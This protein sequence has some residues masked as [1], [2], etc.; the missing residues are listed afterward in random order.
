VSSPF[1]VV[2]ASTG[3]RLA[4][5]AD[6]SLLEVL[7]EAGISILSSCRSGT[8]GTCEVG[9]LD[10]VPEHHDEVLTAEERAAGDVLFVCTARA[11]TPELV[12]DL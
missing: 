8:C 6:R 4:V 11:L 10:G 12:L 1:A 5:P 3:R 2:L 7:E 9:V